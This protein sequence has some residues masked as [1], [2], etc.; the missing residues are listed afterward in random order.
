MIDSQSVRA[1]SAEKRGFDAGTKSWATSDSSYVLSAGLWLD[2]A[3][4]AAQAG[5]I[6]SRL[7][8]LDKPLLAPDPVVVAVQ[9]GPV[10]GLAPAHRRGS[11]RSCHRAV[12]I[13]GGATAPTA[14]KGLCPRWRGSRPAT[15]AVVIA[16]LA[17]VVAAFSAQAARMRHGLHGHQRDCGKSQNCYCRACAACGLDAVEWGPRLRRV[18][19]CHCQLRLAVQG[20]MADKHEEELYGRAHPDGS[21]GGAHPLRELWAAVPL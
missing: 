6:G 7:C 18:I 13:I 12:R 16:S 9:A 8:Q 1:P 5:V 11:S 3:E 14:Q 20:S 17:I 2:A 19:Y 4:H 21:Q 10:A 15:V